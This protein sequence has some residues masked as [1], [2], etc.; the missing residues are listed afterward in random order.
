MRFKN[1][2]S[3]VKWLVSNSVQSHTKLLLSERTCCHGLMGNMN[4]MK[5][6]AAEFFRNL[7]TNIVIHRVIIRTPRDRSLC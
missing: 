4:T 1:V 3:V 2:M 5:K 6:E 7:I